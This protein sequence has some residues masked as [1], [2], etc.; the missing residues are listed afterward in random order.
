MRLPFCLTA[1]AAI[2]F[3]FC[4]FEKAPGVEVPVPL[5]I[6]AGL[7]VIDNTLLMNQFV[8]GDT[9]KLFN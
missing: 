4:S 5:N 1:A 2:F 9:N 6:G 3:V 8:V 7:P